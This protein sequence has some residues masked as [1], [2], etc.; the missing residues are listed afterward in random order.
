[1]AWSVLGEPPSYFGDKEAG[2][3]ELANCLRAAFHRLMRFA[4]A[5]F[6]QR[7]RKAHSTHAV[8]PEVLMA[9]TRMGN[10]PAHA[11]HERLHDNQGD[12]TCRSTCIRLP[13]LQNP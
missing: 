13:T 8:Q 4:S 5:V 9:V 3:D 2:T 6:D 12:G 11:S 7:K 10:N 1:M